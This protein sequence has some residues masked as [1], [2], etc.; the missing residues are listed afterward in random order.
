VFA[1][2]NSALESFLL[3]S[4]LFL[5]LAYRLIADGV[6]GGAA[7]GKRLL[8]IYVVDAATRRPCS[9]GQAAI[10][11]GI[12]VIPFAC[13]IEP[14]VLACDSQQRWGDRVA[15]TYVLRRHPKKSPVTA[16]PSRPLNLAGLSETLK[17]LKT[18]NEEA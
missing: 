10:R 17:K 3:I 11:M 16:T 5:G 4:S 1:P 8:G 9:I 14:V 6:F 18:P 2:R 12:L 7:L 15:R 13:L